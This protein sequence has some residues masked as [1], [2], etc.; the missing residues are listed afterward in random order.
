MKPTP[1][2]DPI[3]EIKAELAD[4]DA[5]RT[6]AQQQTQAWR[7]KALMADAAHQACA[8]LLKKLDKQPIPSVESVDQQETAPPQ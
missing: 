4:Y 7:D 3:A 2:P 6:N 1:K 5:Q 8:A